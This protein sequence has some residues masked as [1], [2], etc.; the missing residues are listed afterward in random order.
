MLIQNKNNL[1]IYERS[2][3]C[4]LI[5]YSLNSKAY[6]LYH[7]PTHKI[8]VSYHVDFIESKDSLPKTFQPGWVLPNISNMLG[9]D[10]DITQDSGFKSILPTQQPSNNTSTSTSPPPSSPSPHRATVSPELKIPQP[11]GPPAPLFTAPEPC[12]SAHEWQ[13]TECAAKH[14]GIQYLPAVQQAVAESQESS[15]QL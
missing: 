6:W 12:L 13:P 11:A 15:C 1:K 4:V 5:G 9:D 14:D 2:Y 10:H 7:C 8:I 3:E